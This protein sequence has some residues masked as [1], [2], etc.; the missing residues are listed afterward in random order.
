[1]LLA[2]KYGNA[3]HVWDLHKRR[4]MQKLEF[5]PEYQM[6][7]ELRPAHNPTETYGFVG[8]VTS[9]KDLSGSIWTWYRDAGAGALVVTGVL[10]YLT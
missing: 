5:G 7:L 1:L 9:L 2:G 6:A 4:H 3:L 8:V 10:T